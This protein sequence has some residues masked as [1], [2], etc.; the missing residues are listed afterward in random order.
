MSNPVTIP[1]INKNSGNSNDIINGKKEE[2]KSKKEE[3]KK[4]LRPE[5]EK[6]LKENSKQNA[7]SNK[8]ESTLKKKETSKRNSITD[9]A[10]IFQQKKPQDNA[11]LANNLRQSLPITK[12]TNKMLE[13]FNTS[14]LNQKAEEKRRSLMYADTN[15]MMKKVESSNVQE[16]KKKIKKI[17]LSKKEEEEEKQKEIKRRKT[18]DITNIKKINEKVISMAQDQ[19]KENE[20]RRMNTLSSMDEKV[21]SDAVQR[22]QEDLKKMEIAKKEE[23]EE[24][25][26][27]IKRKKTVDKEKLA[28]INLKVDT[29]LK[30]LE[31]DHNIRRRNSIKNSSMAQKVVSFNVERM[32]EELINIEIAKKEKEEK[33]QKEIKEKK[34]VDKAIIAK[35]YE[36]IE[37]ME[38]EKQKFIEEKVNTVK[39]NYS[40]SE[41]AK[42]NFKN[43]LNLFQ[44]NEEHVKDIFGEQ[45]KELSEE[46]KMHLFDK[47]IN[48]CEI[49]EKINLNITMKNP[50]KE[51]KYETEIYD[52]E[53]NLIA[54]TEKKGDK[55]E[56]TLSDNSEL[57]YK[58]TKTQLIKIVLTKYTSSNDKIKTIKTIPLKKI[59]SKN[60][61][62]KFE[63]KIEDF[64]DNEV[65][66]IDYGLS[67]ETKDQ[68]VVELNF[69]ALNKD[70]NKNLSYCI[71]KDNKVLFKS[72]VCNSTNIKK[73]DQ[74]KLSD[75][76]PEF[77]I[78][79]YNEE[80]EEKKVTIKTKELKSG[81]SFDLPNVD[82]LKIN[83]SSEETK[84]NSFLKLLE[85]KNINLDLSIAIDFTCSNGLPQNIYSLHYIK[86][87]FMNN[88]EKS[89]REHYKI[90]SLYNK[91]DKYNV[92]GFGADINGEFKKIFN[93][94]GTDNPSITGIENIISEYKK[95]VN[96]VEF[97]GATYFAPIIR[98]VKRKIEEKMDINSNYHILLIISDGEIFDIRETIDS[99]IE[100]SKLPIS[101]IIIGIGADVTSDM[102]TLNGEKG[103]LISSNNE[104]LNKDIVQYVH[105]KDFANNL[106][107]LANEVL[108]YIPQQITSYFKEK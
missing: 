44:L 100:A 46:E 73:S 89:I 105:F 72:A 20:I 63:E 66:N 106:N 49:K 8:E 18:I 62:K 34:I 40:F 81:V 83:I 60:N 57:V 77:Q 61:D 42:D 65:I 16:M 33:I 11:N 54:K 85:E 13:R 102:K 92:Y 19:E 67:E 82:G 108:K 15:S 84:Y 76:E 4:E 43:N 31:G 97:S 7:P 25:Q 69:N 101:F 26:K 27:E 58:F 2:T 71:Q 6:S 96:S 51:Y 3:Q 87:G 64:T 22:V 75:L 48:N 52:E 99:I 9:R 36:R 38:K 80:F 28:E 24:R 79:F 32:K 41:N 70:E 107:K 74:I 95:T 30:V 21:D 94:N 10:A 17:E 103:K 47:K 104:E 91:N 78:S 5:Y 86:D 35:M 53:G 14:V 50:N 59:I 90:I 55:N 37:E 88:Y 29:M 1:Q 23:E 56:I 68:K 12:R 93:L 98:E 45:S 39:T